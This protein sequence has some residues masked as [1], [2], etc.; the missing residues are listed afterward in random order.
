MHPMILIFAM[1]MLVGLYA[2][3]HAESSAS[4][5]H[6]AVIEVDGGRLKAYGAMLR[7]FRD[8]N[9]TFTGQ[10]APGAAGVPAWFAVDGLNNRIS[11]GSVYAYLAAQNP[12]HALAV[13][14][15]CSNG[16]RCGIA[17]AGGLRI[18]GQAGYAPLP[19]PAGIPAGAVV[20]VL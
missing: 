16:L 18:P 7:K 2:V 8:A 17:T 9:P 12:A 15:Q 14:R 11:G 4:R 19:L 3:D 5:A 13:A 1:L 20:I 6:A 10:V